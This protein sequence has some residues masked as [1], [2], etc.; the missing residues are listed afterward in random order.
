MKG[1]SAAEVRGLAEAMRNMASGPVKAGGATL[2]DTCGTGGDGSNSFNFATACALLLA[3]DGLV[4]A[5]HGNRSVSSQC[6]SADLLDGLDIPLSLDPESASRRLA[7]HGF[8]FLFAPAFHG[9]TAAVMPV[10]R[11]L[12][13][14][15]VFN[16]LGPLANPARP[17]YPLVGAWD[18]ATARLM[19]E[20][21]AGM[22]VR[23]AFAVH[24]EPGW[25]E[26]TPVGPFLLCDVRHG[27]VEER[28]VDPREFGV[29]RCRPQDLEGGDPA[30]NVELAGK[31]FGGER[32][33]LRDALVLN[34][35]L[36]YKMMDEESSP[37]AAAAR[38][39][40]VLDDGRV[41]ALLDRLRA[42]ERGEDDRVG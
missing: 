2:V 20:A 28:Q 41:L 38:A 23:R 42:E 36:G 7:E 3:A 29:P 31:L 11:E 37:T 14:R 19:A 1:E 8:A 27:R 15:T 24:G 13:T 26:A 16:V 32:G 30:R 34:A 18:P 39:E 10:R 40:S 21:L 33:P 6:G 9:A 17:D 5:K 12:G 25:D 4:V 35:A 22:D